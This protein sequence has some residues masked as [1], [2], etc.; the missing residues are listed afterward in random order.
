[1]N[2]EDP[3]IVVG[4]TSRL[5]IE[6]C[7]LAAQSNPGQTFIL[8]ARHP[9]ER[10][11]R[12]AADLQAHGAGCV[13]LQGP[14]PPE[15]MWHGFSLLLIC[16]GSLTSQEKASENKDYLRQEW[17]ANTTEILEWMEWGAAQVEKHGGQIAVISSV[18][19]DRAKKSNYTYGA[20]KA[21][22]DFALAGLRHRLH[23]H[24]VVTTIKP[25]PT[26]SPM[27][28]ASPDATKGKPLADPKKV[29]A[30]IWT[31]IQKKAKVVYA[32]SHWKYVMGVIGLIPDAIWHKTNL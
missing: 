5:A 30:C 8:H 10:L 24:G 13:G 31:G 32:P 19:S 22:L 23:G 16:Q 26:T 25:G 17:E 20:A 18:A 15:E 27:T 14:N 11:E 9:L 6:V 21:A 28:D 4:A 7:R 2:P 29:A 12:I 1:M 3:I